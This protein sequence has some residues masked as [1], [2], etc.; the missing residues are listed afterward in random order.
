MKIK[1]V[2]GHW[3][4]GNLKP[5]CLD[6]KSYQLLVDG[7][8]CVH[9]GLAPGCT[10]ST[11]G[12]NSITYNIACCGGLVSKPLT[13]IQV[14]KFYLI[15]AKK[16]KEYGLSPF[17]FYT[18]AEIGEMCRGYKLKLQGKSYDTKHQIITDLLPYNKWLYQNIGKIDLTRLPDFCGNAFETGDYI[19]T[20]IVWYLKRL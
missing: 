8:G 18:H 5:S 9:S 7:E 3:T 4:A 17:S 20:K 19:R 14:E 15:C 2:I 16:V 1:Y 6:L 10:S 12:M 11:G 13:K